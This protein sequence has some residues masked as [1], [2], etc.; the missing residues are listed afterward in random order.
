MPVYVQFNVG[1]SMAK[2]LRI[3]DMEKILKVHRTT[4]YRWC[5]DGFLPMPAKLGKRVV[6]WRSDDIQDWMDR[7]VLKSRHGHHTR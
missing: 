4:I 3:P 5:K 2:F 1:S 6:A 7:Q